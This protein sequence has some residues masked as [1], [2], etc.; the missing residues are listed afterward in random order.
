MFPIMSGTHE[1]VASQ[2]TN[3]TQEKR[4]YTL[5]KQ[6]TRRADSFLLIF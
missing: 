2:R 3:G 6:P 1:G 5:K 4:E